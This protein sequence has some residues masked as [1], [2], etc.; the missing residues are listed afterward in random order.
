MWFISHTRVWY[1]NLLSYA[2]WIQN[3]SFVAYESPALQRLAVL[4]M[5]QII[6]VVQDTHFQ[7][8][9]VENQYMERY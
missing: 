4:L 3:R 9:N 8:T 1:K 7:T 6:E 2:C 5:Q